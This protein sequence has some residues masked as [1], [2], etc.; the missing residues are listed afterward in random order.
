MY[1]L[2]MTHKIFEHSLIGIS[3]IYG[4]KSLKS[5]QWNKREKPS[6]RV[7]PLIYGSIRFCNG[8]DEVTS[9]E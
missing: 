4:R 7:W 6:I 2:N 8:P 3:P 1:D 5:E 9:T